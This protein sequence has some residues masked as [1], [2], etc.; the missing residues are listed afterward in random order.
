MENGGCKFIT[1]NACF[2]RIENGESPRTGGTAA[3]Y[4]IYNRLKYTIRKS[5]VVYTLFFNSPNS[6]FLNCTNNLDI[7]DA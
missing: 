2:R 7:I 3:L 4:I 6:P 5:Y 1:K